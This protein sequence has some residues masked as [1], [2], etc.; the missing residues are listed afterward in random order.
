MTFAVKGWCP[1]A[2]RPMQSGD[3]L[4]VRVRPWN[5]TLSPVQ[6][7][8]IAE[9]ARRHGNGL[10][11]LTQRANLQLRGV[12]PE[13]LV[14]LQ[15]MLDR[16]GLLDRD[17]AAEAIR[18]VMVGP[19]AGP[20]ARTL[21]ADLTEAI[22]ADPRLRGLP[23]KFGWL[24]DDAACPTILDRRG[25]VM[26]CLLKQ[27]VAVRAHGAW[28]GLAD[29]SQAVAAAVDV[30]AG[31]HPRL[32]PLV[33]PPACRR[34]PPGMTAPF[35]RLS[36]DQLS[37]VADLADRA[38]VRE[39][40]IAPWRSLYIDGPMAETT[41]LGLVVDPNDPIL[42][43]DACPGA[44]AC[45]S[46]TVDTRRDAR[47]LADRGFDGTI[48]LSGCAKGCARSA[49]AD[50]VLVGIDGR[51]GVIRNGTPH[52]PVLYTMAPEEL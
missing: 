33:A 14:P 23:A 16:L 5:S 41:A 49:A 10:I 26:L 44:P 18:N 17:P 34:P 20:A 15:E 50:L 29:R 47:R 40:R 27:G 52:D 28:L 43:I 24:V 22:L 19:F 38:G 8:G 1:G 37:G 42:G 11:D 25:D 12:T 35:G 7:R 46:S 31:Q 51:Y 36:A 30:A 21:A 3:G 45:C 2:L 13:A 48:H 9:G 39:I 32:P 4:I 6:A